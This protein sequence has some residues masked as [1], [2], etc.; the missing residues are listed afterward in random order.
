MS[1]SGQPFAASYDPLSPDETQCPQAGWARLREEPPGYGAGGFAF[2]VT[3]H[4]DVVDVVRS[5]EQFSSRSSLATVPDA[6]RDRLPNGYPFDHPALLN[7]DPPGHSRIR[8]LATGALS[9][10]AI[11]RREPMIREIAGQLV[12]AIAERGQADLVADFAVP[13]P[14]L[15]ITRILGLPPDVARIKQWTDESFDLGLP[16]LSEPHRIERALRQAELADV[17]A[18][19]IAQRRVHPR[20]DLLSELVHARV[21]DAPALTDLEVA[22]VVCQL[23]IGGN[24]TTTHFLGNLMYL[25]LSV[26]ERYAALEADRGLLPNT[27]EETLRL[28]PPIKGLPRTAAEDTAVAGCPVR[29]DS[30]VL[31]FFPSANRDEAVFERPDEFDPARPDLNRSVTFGQGIHFCIGAPLAR[32]ES[33]IA[34]E[35]LLD[36]L[37]GLELADREEHRIPGFHYGLSRLPVRWPTAA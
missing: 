34:L 25:L 10:R 16:F 1:S 26:P 15:V 22:A 14:I 35:T 7:N 5:V 3:R 28:V 8:R 37:P 21:D 32:L 24:E 6:V 33:R 31:L 19:L 27:V 11:A 36:R 2:L 18:E 4:A 20:D 13:L 17:L 23:L 12:D 30:L 29:K 9:A